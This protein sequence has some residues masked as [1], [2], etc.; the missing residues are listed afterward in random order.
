MTIDKRVVC[1]CV[2]YL[3][4]IEAGLALLPLQE[5]GYW[6]LAAWTG[7]CVIAGVLVAEITAI[8]SAIDDRPIAKGRRV[9]AR[10]AVPK[11]PS[12]RRERRRGR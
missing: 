4:G 2:V 11:N 6:P 5:T 1:G 9:P 10:N 12:E 7:I 3:A 8:A